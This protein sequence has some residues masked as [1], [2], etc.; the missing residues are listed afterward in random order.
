MAAADNESDGPT[1]TQRKRSCVVMLRDG[2]VSREQK[3]RLGVAVWRAARGG[4]NWLVRVQPNYGSR[5][6]SLT[7][8][9]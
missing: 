7:K 9:F 1:T 4:R 5:G 3:V 2:V 8:G 6:A